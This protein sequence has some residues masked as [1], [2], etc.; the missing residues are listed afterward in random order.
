ME[1]DGAGDGAALTIRIWPG[2]IRVT[3]GRA[4]FHG[5]WVLWAGN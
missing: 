4:G 5:Q 1:A 3:L 2:N